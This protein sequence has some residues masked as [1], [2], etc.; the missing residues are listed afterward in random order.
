MSLSREVDEIAIDL[1]LFTDGVTFIKSSS[2]KSLWPTWF[3]IAQLPP[4]LW[5]SRKN[6]V[7]A[8]LFFGCKKP[9]FEEFLVHSPEE[10]LQR[11]FLDGNGNVVGFRSRV[12]MIVSDLIAKSHFLSMC[13]LN[14]F[15]GCCY[16]TAP[17]ATIDRHYCYYPYSQYFKVHEFVFHTHSVTLS[18]KLKS[19]GQSSI[20]VV[21]VKC[22]SAFSGLVLGL[23]LSASIDYMHCVSIGVYRALLKLHVKLMDEKKENWELHYWN[24]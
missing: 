15:F 9:I 19:E 6:F 11:S 17:G 20:N 16:C 24:R 7:L 8:S 12:I 5:M 4:R 22:R 14:G 10:I 3:S 1:V 21:D 13:Q 2:K 18:E 23:P